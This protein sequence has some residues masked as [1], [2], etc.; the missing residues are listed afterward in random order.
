M[1][2]FWRGLPLHSH[3]L[4]PSAS[5]LD[6]PHDRATLTHGAASVAVDTSLLG[7]TLPFRV[8]ALVQVIG[9]LELRQGRVV[10]VARVCRAVDGLNMDLYAKSVMAQRAFLQRLDAAVPEL[11]KEVDRQ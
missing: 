7:A 10:L 4:S 1:R 9:E 6:L 3:H 8:G 2:G 11:E 5:V